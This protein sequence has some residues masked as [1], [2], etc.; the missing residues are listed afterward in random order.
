MYFEYVCVCVFVSGVHQCLYNLYVVTSTVCSRLNV[1][2]R[3]PAR[4]HFIQQLS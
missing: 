4:A 2:P 3:L 1:G